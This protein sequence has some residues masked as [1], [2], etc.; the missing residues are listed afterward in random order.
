MSVT[1]LP[2]TCWGRVGFGRTAAAARAVRVS[3]FGLVFGVWGSG[4]GVWGLGFVVC[5]LGFVVCGLWFRGW[6]SWRGVW[7]LEFGVSCFLLCLLCL[8]VRFPG[9]DDEGGRGPCTGVGLMAM[10]DSGLV[11]STHTHAGPLWEGYHESRRFSRDTY[12]ESYITK[13]TSMRR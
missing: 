5:G 11:G 10:I 9:S 4:F 12:P 7:G 13:Y 3:R 8:E 1:S 6:G 2:I